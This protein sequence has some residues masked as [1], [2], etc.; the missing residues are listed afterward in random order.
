M[1]VID[2]VYN[3]N[4]KDLFNSV[5]DIFLEE[6]KCRFVYDICCSVKCFY[7]CSIVYEDLKFKNIFFDFGFRV[8][9]CDFGYFKYINDYYEVNLGMN[10]YKLLEKRE[11]IISSFIRKYDRIKF[12]IFSFGMI[13][14]EIYRM[15]NEI[16][17]FSIWKLCKFFDIIEWLLCNELL[18]KFEYIRVDYISFRGIE[19]YFLLEVERINIVYYWS[20]YSEGEDE[21]FSR[22]RSLILRERYF[23]VYDCFYMF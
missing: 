3:L 5:G 19:K 13:I 6:F 9:I 20:D 1:I 10:I 2:F 16:E 17:V 21:F 7:D 8:K 23:E 12:D 11:I 18:E 14:E 22:C 4:L 15:F